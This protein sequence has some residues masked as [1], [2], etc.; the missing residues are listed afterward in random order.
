MSAKVIRCV[1]VFSF[2]AP[3]VTDRFKINF[4]KQMNEFSM[5]NINK[6]N[7]AIL[8]KLKNKTAQNEANIS[9]RT[10]FIKIGKDT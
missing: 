9:K 5:L 6:T 1:F 8:T 2:I 4:N 3:G 7:A 10:L